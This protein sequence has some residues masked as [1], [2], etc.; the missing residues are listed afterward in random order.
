M[1]IGKS[2]Q[3]F[4]ASNDIEYT[5]TDDIIMLNANNVPI[6][7]GG[8]IPNKNVSYS[9]K[10][11]SLL[12]EGSVFN[13]AKIRQQSRKLGLRTDRSSR[14]EKSLKNVGAGLKVRKKHWKILPN[15]C[16][17]FMRIF[18]IQINFFKI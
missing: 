16:L 1:G 3:K 13:A 7:I 17:S 8:I 15:P 14:Y 4:L 6:S 2:N 9:S 18:K 11:T 10:T 12:I 5:L